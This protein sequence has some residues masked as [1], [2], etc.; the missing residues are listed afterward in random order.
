M[1]NFEL[2]LYSKIG[3]SFIFN[4]MHYYRTGFPGSQPVSMDRNNLRLLHE[5]PYMVSWKADGTRYLM[6]IDG[7][8]EIYFIDRDNCVFQAPGV[9]FPYRKNPEAHIFDTLVDGVSKTI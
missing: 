7:P 1:D 6:L 3:F 4:V 2:S 8:G 5:K 9:T